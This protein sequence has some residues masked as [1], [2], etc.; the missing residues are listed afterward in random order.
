MTGG[1]DVPGAAALRGRVIS[2]EA[3]A[4]ATTERAFARADAVGAGRDRLNIVLWEDRERSRH[5]ASAIDAGV[6]QGDLTGPMAGVPVAVKDNIATL[7][8]PTT[9][10]SLLVRR[11]T[12]G[13][14]I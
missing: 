1:Y 6:A 9:C 14:I 2:G 11:R 8:L 7:Q 4:L 13:R 10:G 12:K 5:D 3:S